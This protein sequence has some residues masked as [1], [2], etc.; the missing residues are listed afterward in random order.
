M[1]DF[2][3]AGVGDPALDIAAVLTFG[4]SFFGRFYQVY[5]EI[6][7]MLE[8]ARFYRGLYALEEALYGLEHDDREAFE[9]GIAVYR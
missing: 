8:R 4:E 5:P 7:A 6:T 9:S 1:I 3:F 2:G